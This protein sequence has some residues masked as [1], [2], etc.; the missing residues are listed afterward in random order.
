MPSST[1][2]GPSSTKCVDALRRARCA[3]T[4]AKRPVGGDAHASRPGVV[5]SDGAGEAPGDVRDERNARLAELQ[6]EHLPLERF[7]DVVHGPGVKRIGNGEW[8]ALH[9]RSRSAVQAA[10]TASRAP[11]STTCSGPFSAAIAT[12]DPVSASIDCTCAQ[13]AKTDTIAPPGGRLH[14]PAACDDQARGIRKR[15]HSGHARGRVLPRRCDRAPPPARCPTTPPQRSQRVL[16]RKQRGLCVGCV[17]DASTSRLSE[18]RLE[19]W[20]PAAADQG[21]PRT[22]PAR[23]GTRARRRTG[24]GPS[25]RTAHP[26][27]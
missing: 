13:V 4:A 10:S 1:G 8:T 24:P 15:Q 9:A 6:P 25:R 26:D 3:S 19:Q 16:H 20:R 17:L 14:Q 21:P 23:H 5:Q 11:L 2:C 7:K 18:H 12:G 27:P 22:R